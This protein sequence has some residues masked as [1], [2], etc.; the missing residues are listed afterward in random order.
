MSPVWGQ[1]GAHLGAAVCGK[2]PLGRVRIARKAWV[3][4]HQSMRAKPWVSSR[5]MACAKW[6]SMTTPSPEFRAKAL[7]I[8]RLLLGYYGDPALKEKRDPLSELVVTILSQNTADVNSSRAYASLRRRFATWDDVLAATT[9]EV[10]QAVRIGGLAN[11]KAARIQDIFRQLRDERGRLD[12]D[13]LDEMSV[14]EARQ[15]LTS[16][17]G[18]GL[19]TAA[20]VLLF[21]LHKPALPVDTHVLRVARRLGLIPPKATA[22][23]ANPLLENLLPQETYYP[24]HM[25]LIR[26]GRTLCKAARPRCA[27]CPLA[28]D[29]DY[30]AATEEMQAWSHASGETKARSSLQEPQ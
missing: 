10:A 23:K 25:S 4:P 12:L 3:A 15:Y 20:C 13:F 30:L 5:P 26:H 29:C 18:V 14:A 6:E 8:H 1:G 7:C 11:T 19:K 9:E 2:R 17:P 28:P 21:S 22:E 16:L 24:F 27:E